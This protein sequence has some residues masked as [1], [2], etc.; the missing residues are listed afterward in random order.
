MNPG[1][2]DQSQEARAGGYGP[3]EPPGEPGWGWGS[4][5]PG[6]LDRVGV[7][8]TDKEAVPSLQ[9]SA[10]GLKVNQNNPEEHMSRP[11]GLGF[12]SGIR[13]TVRLWVEMLLLNNL[14]LSQ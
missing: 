12:R 3:D 13:R 5:G 6:A 1:N 11:R 7:P 10:Q 2:L 8:R 14:I 9:A 4:V